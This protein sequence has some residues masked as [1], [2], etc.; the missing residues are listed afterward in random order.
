MTI[1]VPAPRL[2]VALT[3]D[4]DAISDAIRRGDP[5]V[6][7]SHGEF[8]PRVGA[9]RILE[10]L[11]SRGSRRRGSCRATRSRR[12]RSRPR[13]SVAGGHELASHGWYH[14]DFAELSVDEQRDV[15]ARSF[16]ALTEARGG[17]PPTGWRAPYWS[18]G[19]R[20]L[21][22]VEAAGF[23]YDSSLMAD[24]YRALPG[25]AR[26]PPQRRRRARAGA[27]RVGLVEVP[28]YWAMDDWPHFEP[29]PGAR[30]RRPRRPVEGPRDL[31]VRA[32]LR[33]R[34][35]AGRAADGDD[36]PRVHR[37]RPPDGDA[38]AVHRRGLG[39]RGRRLRAPRRGT[40]SGSRPWLA[41]RL[42]SLSRSRARRPG[43]RT[44]AEHRPRQ[45]AGERVLL[46]R[47]VRADEHVRPDPRLR[48]VAEPRPWPRHR[49]LAGH[50][51]DR[52][53][54]RLPAVGAERH[55]HP[56]RARAA[57]ARG[58]RNGAQ[59]SR[60]DGSGLFAGG[61]HRTAAAT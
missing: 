34:P 21:E 57:P 47:V 33:L 8:G 25:P 50:R 44:S 2:T 11:A 5:P 16:E 26:R 10:L 22:L 4:H 53:Q 27:A 7:L 61:A 14:E 46:A 19:P 30:P 39:P 31:D 55:E 3:F 49:L 54:R 20:T 23:R 38:G 42:T 52:P 1:D 6:K 12:S 45:L 17:T 15:L 43:P 41:G 40:W 35:R 51:R 9:P 28:V 59:L 60:S 18:L 32:A 48:P 36:A 37:P 13:R 58:A 56:H 24:D 29:A